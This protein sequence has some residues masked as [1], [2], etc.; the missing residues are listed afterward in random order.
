MTFIIFPVAVL[1]SSLRIA[2]I[3]SLVRIQMVCQDFGMASETRH[4]QVVIRRMTKEWTKN[5]LSL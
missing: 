3:S 4:A 5:E 2:Y 1:F